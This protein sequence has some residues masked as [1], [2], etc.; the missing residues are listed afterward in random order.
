M[1]P[2]VP[3]VVS[4]M[5]GLAQERLTLEVLK[6]ERKNALEADLA[7]IR[8]EHEGGL[9]AVQEQIDSL[10]G[11]IW[12]LAADHRSELLPGNERSFATLAAT[13]RFRKTGGGI[14]VNDAE[15]VMEIARKL[16]I[17]RQVASPPSQ[18]WKLCIKKLTAW[19]AKHPELLKRFG[20]ALKEIPK[21]ESL[22]IQP[23]AGYVTIFDNERISPPPVGIKKPAKS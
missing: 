11:R 20:T 1:T 21:S 18:K 13:F 17:V 6:N 19:A 15:E 16:G 4:T 7:S 8:A 14:K 9:I 2:P 23:N 12:K 22:N 10:D 3:Q 5:N